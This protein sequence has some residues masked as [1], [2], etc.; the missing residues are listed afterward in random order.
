MPKAPP[1]A[2]SPELR[3]DWVNVVTLCLI[4]AMASASLW[5]G[6]DSLGH[7]MVVVFTSTYLVCD[8]VWVTL[9]PAIVRTPGSIVAHHVVTL[10]VIY[11]T[12]ENVTHRVNASRALLVEINTVLLT[13]RRRLGRPVWCEAAFYATWGLLRLV[14][15]PILSVAMLAS[16]FG[17]ADQLRASMPACLLVDVRSP[18]P[19]KAY[20]SISFAAVVVLQYYWTFTLLRSLVCGKAGAAEALLGRAARHSDAAGLPARS[21]GRRG[22]LL[23]LLLALLGGSALALLAGSAL[24]GLLRQ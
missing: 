17:F 6:E 14:W 1:A 21:D 19:I 24:V 4:F 2:A 22:V 13:L 23:P 20:A 10:V 12:V 18:P 15:F 3:H 16:T 7:T 9:Q 5:S 11:G 8:I